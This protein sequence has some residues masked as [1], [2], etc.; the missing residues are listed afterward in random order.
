MRHEGEGSRGQHTAEGSHDQVLAEAD[1]DDEGDIGA[2]GEVVAVGEVGDALDAEDERGADAGQG[3]DGAADEA[4]D[5]ELDELFSHQRRP[6]PL[7]TLVPKGEAANVQP[8]PLAE[9]APS[10][11]AY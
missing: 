2:D 10:A 1:V 5:D 8:G 6:Q 9:D 4:V 11:L 7:M 3:Q